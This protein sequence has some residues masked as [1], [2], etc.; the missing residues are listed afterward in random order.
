MEPKDKY[1]KN[2]KLEIAWLNCEFEDIPNSMP[3]LKNERA[4]EI[5]KKRNE[6]KTLLRTEPN[7]VA[8][9]WLNKILKRK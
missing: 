8:D 3:R 1:I 5:L 6:L 9:T 2:L 4:I 7:A